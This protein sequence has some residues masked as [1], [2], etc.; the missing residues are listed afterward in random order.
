MPDTG[1]VH[2][3]TTAAAPAATP[4]TSTS[5]PSSPPNT[6]TQLGLRFSPF[7]P[8]NNGFYFIVISCLIFKLQGKSLFFFLFFLTK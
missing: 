5:A 3:Q 2:Q 8:M 1:W 7:A 4:T 6:Y